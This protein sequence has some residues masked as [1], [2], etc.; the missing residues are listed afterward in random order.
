VWQLEWQIVKTLPKAIGTLVL[1][2]FA[3]LASGAAMA[4]HRGGGHGGGGHGYAHGG[5][6]RFGI[7]LGLPIFGLGYYAAPYYAYPAPVYGYPAPAYA[8]PAAPY[9]YP[10]AVMGSASPQAYVEQNMNQAV[11]P[12]A[13]QAQGDWYYCAASKT[14]YPYVSECPAGWQRVPAQPLTR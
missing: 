9:S 2:A 10:G 14:Y 3:T 7:S 6:V 12:P 1:V 4:Q 8:Y 5:G 13:P 11:P